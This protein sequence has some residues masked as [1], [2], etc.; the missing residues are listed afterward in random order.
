MAWAW[1]VYSRAALVSLLM[2]FLDAVFYPVLLGMFRD[3]C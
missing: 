3:F 2:E 1:V